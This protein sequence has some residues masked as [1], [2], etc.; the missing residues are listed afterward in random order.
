MPH[1]A[2]FAAPRLAR[3]GALAGVVAAAT[4]RA[5]APRA[6]PVRTLR[7]AA[8]FDVQGLEP[9]RSGFV[10]ARMQ[11]A[12]TLVAVTPEGALVPQLAATV[13][14]SADH[15]TWHFPIRPGA[16]FHDGTPVTPEAVAASLDRARRAAGSPLRQVPF[17]AIGAEGDA[18][19]ITLTRGFAVLPAYLAHASA[20]VLAPAAYAADGTVRAMLATGPYRLARQDGSVLVEVE[21]VRGEAQ[22]GPAIQRA[23]YRAVADGETRARMVEAGD[24]ELAV[25][26]L[27]AAA[28]RLRRNPQLAVT[29]TALPRVRY[30][31]ANAAHPALADVRVRTAL[32]LGMDRAGTA[33][34][35][36]RNA[37]AAATQLL[38]PA[39]AAWHAPQ[40]LVA[41]D[42][43]AAA[44]LLDEAGWVRGAGGMRAR[45][46]QPLA[47]ELFTYAARPELPPLAEAMQA[48]WQSLGIQVRIVLGDPDAI[49]ARARDGS[50]HLALVARNYSLIPEPIGTFAEDFL[51]DSPT[52]GWGA[53]G[54]R[55]AAVEAAIEAYRGTT[56]EAVRAAS[57]AEITR[58]L[59]AE[60]PIIPH[61]WYDQFVAASRRVAGVVVDPF[62]A[63]YGIAA[64][65]WVG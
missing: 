63:S 64:M 5:A 14:A 18:V 1:H 41:H 9:A 2:L 22:G 56:D 45:N 59:H 17:A 6:Q 49:P 15:R 38:P 53:A 30:V 24:A 13:R 60:L 51:A 55:S 54:W 52:R 39:L 28:E 4:L 43:A 40:T 3:R 42:P 57:R 25:T 32:S 31:I 58:I 46:G 62:E 44:R 7:I 23:S 47:L 34:A 61:S 37:D 29:A 12:E 50:L 20:M 11:V 10:F 21:A 48:Q 27:P 65:R 33:R 26:L 19:L 35:I 8:P 16:T 36:L